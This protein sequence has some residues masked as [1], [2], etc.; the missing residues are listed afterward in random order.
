MIK[1]ATI[2]PC[3]KYR[4]DLQRIWDLNL[5]MACLVG[6]NPSTADA[7]ENDR[8]IC[9][10]IEFVKTWGCGGF[11]MVNLF[12]YRAT[13]PEDMLVTE[14]PVGAFNNEH[15][16]NAAKQAAKVVFCWGTFGGFQKRDEEII[17]MFPDAECFG[18]TK[19]GHPIHPLYLHSSTQLEKFKR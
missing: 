19:H 10:I 8:T 9:R 12:A 13:R 5:P 2:S 15:I 3:G 1:T 16:M 4:Y 11:T 14:H 6:L 7:N 18:Y 17:A